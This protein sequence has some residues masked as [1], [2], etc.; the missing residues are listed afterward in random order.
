MPNTSPIIQTETAR[1]AKIYEIIPAYKSDRDAQLLLHDTRWKALEAER[2]DAPMCQKDEITSRMN[3]L[4]HQNPRIYIPPYENEASPY[5]GIV[6]IHDDDTK[7]GAK[8]YVIGKQSLTFGVKP[9]VVD[10]RKA[11]VSR[12]FYEYDEGEDYDEEFVNKQGA[13]DRTGKITHKLFITISQ[14]ALTDIKTSTDSYKN[15]NGAWI[16]KDGNAISAPISADIK[17]DTGDHQLIDIIAL[18]SKEQF[19]SITRNTAGCCYLTGGA[20]SGK[21]TVALHRLSYLQF[22]EPQLFNPDKCL[23]LVFNRTLKDYVKNTSKELL[24]TTAV[25]TFTAWGI[26][27]IKSLGGGTID[28]SI[29]QNGY[30]EIKKHSAIEWL[31]SMYIDMNPKKE[32]TPI[33]D[34]MQFYTSDQ[35][36]TYFFKDDVDSSK[37]LKFVQLHSKHDNKLAYADVGVLLRLMQLRSKSDEI[38][39]AI[40]Y[41]D[42]IVADEAQ[43]FAQHEL[44]AIFAALN[45]RKSLTICADEKQKILSFVD[46]SGLSNFKTELNSI[47]L[48][49]TTFSVGFRSAPEIMDVANVVAGR[50]ANVAGSSANRSLVVS[51]QDKPTLKHNNDIVT[52]TKVTSA[53][54]ALPEIINVI[55]RYQKQDPSSL[56]AI[57]CKNKSDIA[58][59]HKGISTDTGIKNIHPAGTIIFTP[60][61]IAINAHQ[62]KGLEFTNV[63]LWNPSRNIYRNN[64]V[65]KN[66]LY[67]AIS[68]ACK[69]LAIIHWDNLSSWFKL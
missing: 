58:V 24:G 63:I 30:D 13:I 66:L 7:I 12:F 56:T 62:V 23:V 36:A 2:F 34:L 28:F 19:R 53:Y 54:T 5:L 65:D 15:V 69:K 47:G 10:W 51:P 68:R 61:V 1:H 18:I 31:L 11:N 41:Y 39:G 50:L 27:A 38:R 52:I 9:Y 57:I 33:Q 26:A 44:E 43:D 14:K 48:D 21:T 8:E 4:E 64:E 40:G 22:N 49:K 6:G 16:T 29:N 59:I 67:V 17:T 55:K 37:M 25:D 3:A 60:G 46:A 45:K 32:L 42:H 35:C 20:G